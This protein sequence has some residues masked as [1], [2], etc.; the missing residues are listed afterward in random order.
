MVNDSQVI[1]FFAYTYSRDDIIAEK[2]SFKNTFFFGHCCND[3]KLNHP[4]KF[5]FLHFFFAI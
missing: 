5:N 2:K 4:I 1:D 3:T